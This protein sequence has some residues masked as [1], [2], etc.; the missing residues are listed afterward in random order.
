MTSRQLGLA[1]WR[2]QHGLDRVF[3][4]FDSIAIAR[5][6]QACVLLPEFFESMLVCLIENT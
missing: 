3:G 2:M 6:L 1:L 4:A 5:T